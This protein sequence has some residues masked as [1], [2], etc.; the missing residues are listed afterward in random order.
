MPTK[1]LQA[2]K[3]HHYVWADYMTRWSNGDKNVWH[4]T[5]TN[6]IR[7]DSVKSFSKEEYFYK[8]EPLSPE[9]VQAI[10]LW[11][12]L[13]PE[14]LHKQHMSYLSDYLRI[15]QLESIYRKSKVR[16]KEIERAFHAMKCNGIENYHASHEGEVKEVI[17]RLSQGDMEA[18]Q[19]KGNMI[20]FIMFF[21]HQISRTKAF[22]ESIST[23][24]TLDIA[25]HGLGEKIS[26]L[27]K[28]C[29]W[30]I[31]Y[32]FGMSIGRSLYLDRNN[33]T[34]CLLI[35][36]TKTSFITSDQPIIN[37]HPGLSD[38]EIA[39]PDSDECDFYYPISPT[40]AYMI[41]KSGRF[42]K[43]KTSISEEVACEMNIK[44]AKKARIH[45]IGDSRDS[46]SP[47]KK[48]IGER[49]RKVKK[50]HHH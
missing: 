45:I 12:S 50:T 44:M 2:K 14:D 33:D 6:K 7:L 36:N 29:W 49:L 23:I 25:Q 15:Q 22:K 47:Y 27:T 40:S 1:H 21:G 24:S 48:Y 38:D 13:S 20:N 34:H 28:E 19:E 26:K 17:D 10:K 39:P 4:T 37:V 9:H 3:N 35:N 18:L 46:L 11:S 31:S 16:D 5:K 32:M 43:G 8:V 42:P 41:N 30:F